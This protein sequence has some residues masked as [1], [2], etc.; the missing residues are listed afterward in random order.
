[1]KKAGTAQTK[2]LFLLVFLLLLG[3]GLWFLLGLG[4]LP[5]PAGASEGGNSRGRGE[6]APLAGRAS[7]QGEEGPER[8]RSRKALAAP[9]S[10]RGVVE[11]RVF[12]LRDGSPLPGVTVEVAREFPATRGLQDLLGNLFRRGLW[13]RRSRPIA[14]P[15][16]AA[17]VTGPSG[18]FRIEGLPAGRF[19]LTLGPGFYYAYRV[20]GVSL[21]PG[22]KRSGVEIPALKGGMVRG[23]ILDW[24]GR[25]VAGAVLDLRPG[26]NSF[27]SHFFGTGYHWRSAFS[28]EAG[29]FVL[30][31]VPPGR[32]YVL[33]A[34]GPGLPIQV[35]TDLEVSEG[36]V[37]EVDFHGEKPASVSGTVRDTAG[38]PLPGARVAVA[39][40]DL[41]EL[42]FSPEACPP[43]RA[44]KDG[45]FE[46]GNLPPGPLAV[47]ARME[48]KG[49]ADPEE[50]TLEAGQRMEGIELV[51]GEGGELSGKVT[52]PEGTP[53][54][55]VLVEAWN[56]SFR[57]GLE[58]SRLL[59]F[60][61]VQAGTKADGTFKLE[62]LSGGRCFL[63]A[64][65]PGY[66]DAFLP[67]VKVGSEDLKIVLKPE[68]GIR[69]VVLAKHTSSPVN[70]FSI[71]LRGV[72]FFRKEKYTWEFEDSRGRFFIPAVPSGKAAL[73]VEARGFVPL[74]K[75]VEVRPGEGA[76][77]VILLLERESLVR[78]R[79]VDAR[80]NPVA[81]ARVAAYRGRIPPGLASLRAGLSRSGRGGGGMRVSLGAGPPGM[82]PRRGPPEVNPMSL[83][84]GWSGPGRALSGPDG[85]FELRG[86]SRG[87]WRVTALHPDHAPAEPVDVA[88]SPD[89]PAVNVVLRMRE[90]ATLWGYVTDLRG[91]PVAHA[92]VAAF[93]FQGGLRSDTTD[94]KGLYRI[95]HLLPGRWYVFKS[96]VLG[97]RTRNIAADLLGNMRLKSVRVPKEGEV[98][99]DISD[100]VE[101][102]VDVEGRVL[103]G[104]KP[105]PGAVV[106]ALTGRGE[107]P[108]GIGVRST[109]AD[110]QGRYHLYSLEPGPYVF[111]VALLR[112]R[113][114][115]LPVEVPEGSRRFHKDLELPVSRISGTV[116]DPSGKPVRGA[117]VRAVPGET[118]G[119]GGILSLI[120][121]RGAWR[122]RTGGDGEFTLKRVPA[123]TYELEVEPPR[124]RKDLG[125]ASLPGLD[126]DG[127][128]DLEGIR[129]VLPPAG[130]LEGT[131][132][133]GKGKPLGGVTVRAVREGKKGPGRATLAGRVRA[134]RDSR[135]Y[136][137]VTKE[138]G[139]FRIRGVPA[140]KWKVRAEKEGFAPAELSGLE[141]LQGGEARADLVLHQ[142]GTVKVQVL[143]RTGSPLPRSRIHV[144]DA[145]GKEVTPTLSA[146][147]L[148]GSL[149]GLG[150]KKDKDGW[151][152]LKN[153]KPGAYTVVV[154][155]PS[156]EKER[157]PV[158]VREGEVTEFRLVLK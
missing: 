106:T 156:G 144:L 107:G 55:G 3:G 148:L 123:G 2:V 5:S 146:A 11:G 14:P 141:L 13:E 35:R 80:G 108:L 132:R 4:N 53:L 94:R 88:V 110:A 66:G 27:L 45:S 100:V 84:M 111:Q 101:G 128:T 34:F 77:G 92:V 127:K 32:E 63:K 73:R 6:A 125:E 96:R 93:S 71:R 65:L 89:A 117:R 58:M 109:M 142:G 155:K 119:G 85:S 122:G 70:R 91:R 21:G 47:A 134:L 17:G 136:R 68:A 50:V 115:T 145:S 76:K 51:V 7:P 126:V 40:L 15:P 121:S 151:Y 10:G 98:R 42:F 81:G 118:P 130:V 18:R 95:R 62:G 8:G 86:L 104:G 133:D 147:R 129:L 20:P 135:L 150:G 139:S 120:V 153:V 46:I 113:P 29:R 78:G 116:L 25:P 16:V 67:R 79:V 90:G 52:D 102:G 22:G 131:V 37:L 61:R 23:R 56:G 9:R 41:H 31:G 48:G 75:E 97:H 158:R 124:E 59:T 43:V 87:K 69:G 105:V 1:M 36:T 30:Q 38:N 152:V 157:H 149:F 49:L 28:D 82:G 64:S 112:G 39:F 26:L 114:S 137:T 12:S 24:Q 143:N 72:P 44:G 103:R 74:D 99:L 57:G 140:G 54:K 60:G 154:E 83:L 138:D 33:T 19:W